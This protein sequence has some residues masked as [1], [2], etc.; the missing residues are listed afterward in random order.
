MCPCL[1]TGV[2]V[3]LHMRCAGGPC[4]H[5]RLSCA[6]LDLHAACIQL[7]NHSAEHFHAEV[8]QAKQ[9]FIS[10][11]LNTVLSS[12]ECMHHGSPGVHKSATSNRNAF[13]MTFI[14]CTACLGDKL[15]PE[16]R[17]DKW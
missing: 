6:H 1:L 5:L 2:L 3:G 4:A 8:Q 17:M 15:P 10:K 14:I 7:V 16:I 13:H 12:V 11:L 9:N